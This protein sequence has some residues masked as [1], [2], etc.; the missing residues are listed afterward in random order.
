M[1][2]LIL[3]LVQSSVALAALYGIYW[4]FLRNDTFFVLN[5]LYLIISAFFSLLI[6]IFRLNPNDYEVV[7]S[8]IT[9]LDP[10]LII[11]DRI[12]NVIGVN[13]KLIEVVGIIYL[14][15][16]VFFFARFIIQLLQILIL[17]F[18]Y[19]I[20]TEK[21]MKLVFVNKTIAPFSFFNLV[22]L[23]KSMIDE[24]TLNMILLHERVH[25]S[26]KHSLDL[27]FMGILSFFF[28]FNPFAW[29]M[30]RSIKTIHEFLADEGVLKVGQNQNH[31]Q[32][33]LMN[34]TPGFYVPYLSN[35]FNFSLI[36][37]RI[38]MMTKTRSAMLARGKVL[39]AIPA[40]IAL[41]FFFSAGS[42]RPLKAQELKNESNKATNAA[43]T[44]G[45][46]V[47]RDQNAVKSVDKQPAYTGGNEA[48]I[49]FLVANIK[50]PEEAKKKGIQG[51]V[52]VSF[53]VKA[54]GSI[55]DVKVKQGIGSGCDEEAIRVIKMM[56]KWV[57]GEV[58]GK[59]V[60]IVCVL[61]IMFQ[62][63]NNDKKKEEPKK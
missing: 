51:K 46:T 40:M 37:Y 52:F 7:K 6:P 61:P 10:V 20:Q 44:S 30:G 26:Q 32:Y 27:L 39:F 53:I 35:N 57:P 11:P 55:S 45:S 24:K 4:V 19:G 13:L 47:Q 43:K 49:K 17:V 36:K 18:H 5:R 34:Q 54:D 31:Y 16:V 62:L 25:I 33:V 42:L 15:G 8:A 28:W 38:I 14:I 22:F 23:P 50:Y 21:G 63:D 9:Y 56:P 2:E 58:K 29:F 12:G 48:Q 41:V 60:D 3:Y 59:P 1:K